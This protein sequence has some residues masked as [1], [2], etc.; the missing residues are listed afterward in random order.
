MGV[1]KICGSCSFFLLFYWLIHF[2]RRGRTRNARWDW[3]GRTIEGDGCL[4]ELFPRLLFLVRTVFGCCHGRDAALKERFV[5]RQAG[6]IFLFRSA[7]TV[8]VCRRRRWFVIR[9]MCEH[10]RAQVKTSRWQ[11]PVGYL[12]WH[13]YD[14]WVDGMLYQLTWWE[15]LF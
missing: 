7:A 11:P 3:A 4:A 15:L 1:F 6:Y 13:W 5:H 2:L 12:C 9:V 14:A 8:C 10:I